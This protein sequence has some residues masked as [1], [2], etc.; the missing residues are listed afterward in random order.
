MSDRPL[1]D[2]LEAV[3]QNQEWEKLLERTLKK[4]EVQG[5]LQKAYKAIIKTSQHG[6][7]GVDKL[8]KIEK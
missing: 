1:A 4:K 3:E 6:R 5:D 8:F 7:D 2:H